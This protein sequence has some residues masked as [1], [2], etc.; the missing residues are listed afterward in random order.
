MSEKDINDVVKQDISS[1][2]EPIITP[3]E[4]YALGLVHQCFG[5]LSEETRAF[6]RFLVEVRHGIDW[7]E[8]N[9][10]PDEWA[11]N[12]HGQKHDL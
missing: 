4:G 7:E 11:L 1:S 12:K 10:V 3:E 8:F 5:N 6:I 9:Q 2:R